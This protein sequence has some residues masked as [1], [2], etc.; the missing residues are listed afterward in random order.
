[1]E[2]MTSEE[3]AS[4]RIGATLQWA[5]PLWQLGTL[6]IVAAWLG[7]T[8]RVLGLSVLFGGLAFALPHYWYTW[9]VLGSLGEDATPVRVYRRF[10]R[11]EVHKMGLTAMSCAL[12]FV[13]LQ[14]LNDVGFFLA[15]LAMMVL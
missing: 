1:M 11:G 6:L 7:D 14:P 2:P 8:N 15:F 5:L 9:Y 13:T 3:V 4:S 10:Q 12:A